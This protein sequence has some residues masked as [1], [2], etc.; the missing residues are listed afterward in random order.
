MQEFCLSQNIVVTTG[1]V[2][3]PDRLGELSANTAGE[4]E[5][6]P[7]AA[8]SGLLQILYVFYY[9]LYIIV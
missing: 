1:S 7:A 5:D 8:E 3:V 2:S 6:S 4:D 9:V